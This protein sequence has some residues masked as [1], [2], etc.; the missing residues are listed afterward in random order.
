MTSPTF[1]SFAS[2]AFLPSHGMHFDGS[3]TSRVYDWKTFRAMHGGAQRHASATQAA[4]TQPDTTPP[5]TTQ[6][7]AAAAAAPQQSAPVSQNVSSAAPSPTTASGYLRPGSIDQN[8][9]KAM[10]ASASLGTPG[11]PAADIPTGLSPLP[12]ATG[13]SPLAPINALAVQQ[14]SSGLPV[15]GMPATGSQTTATA[16]GATAIP[17]LSAAQFAA[18]T[19]AHLAAPSP[20]TAPGTGN[21]QSAIPGAKPGDRHDNGIPADALTMTDAAI[22]PDAPA[23]PNGQAAT[24]SQ[25]AA[26]PS[27]DKTTGDK[28][29]EGKDDDGVLKL[30]QIP[31]RETR[32][33]YA[34]KGIKW[35]LVDDPAADKLF[36]GP[37]GK[38]SWDDAIDLINPL[39]H[40]PGL[41]IIYRELTGDKISGAA[42]LLG[43][44]PFGPLSTLS[45]VVNLAVK[46]TTG[47]DIGEN[48]IAMLTGEDKNDPKATDMAAG[49]PQPAVTA[50]ADQTAAL[51]G[52]TGIELASAYTTRDRTFGRG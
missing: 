25:A 47:R 2:N 52:P 19:G 39:Q 20:V 1:S 40:I 48:A 42:E 26:L 49:E 24:G 11:R 13:R 51:A 15:P 27:E 38:L 28:S 41:N 29:G 33:E 32:R 30:T 31:D 35:K 45:A 4:T 22:P 12:A 34:D 21:P 44:I 43:A 7:P 6:S 9:F 16:T 18:L 8:Q 3:G 17:T 5:A 10:L 36:F 50:A 37:D 14:A 46:S 23:A